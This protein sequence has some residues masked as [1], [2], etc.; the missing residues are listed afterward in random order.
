MNVIMIMNDSLRRDHIAAYGAPPPWERP[1]HAGEPFILTPNLDR[2]AAESALFERFYLSSYPTIPCRHDIFTGR[3]GFPS[4][5]WQ[6]LEPGDVI[7]SELVRQGGAT[8]ATIFDTPML[9]ADSY[10]FARGFAGWDFVRG[11]HSDRYI[12]DPIPTTL[13]AAPHKLKSVPATQLYLRNS[14]SRTS[15]NDWMCARTLTAAM[16][17]LERNRTR[18]DFVLCLDMWDPHEPFDAPDFDLARYADP[19]YEGESNIYPRYGRPDY[20]SAA[21]HN[22]VRALYAA[23]VT[24][25]D[26]WLGRLLEKMAALGLDK[27]TLLLFYTDHGHLFGEHNL[28]GKPTGPLGSLYEPTVRLPLLIRHPDGV[29]AGK[30][31]QGIAQ[32]PDLLPTVLEFLGIPTPDTVHGTS[33]WPLIRGETDD[34]RQFAV[35]GRYSRLLNTGP[36]AAPRRPDAE[37]FDGAAGVATEA[38]PLTLTTREWAYICPPR[39][40]TRE[41]YH[42]ETDPDQTD[43]V[44][45]RHPRVAADLHAKLLSFLEAHGAPADRIALYRDPERSGAR[46]ALMADETPLFT[47]EDG[48]GHVLAFPRRTAAEACLGPAIPP[49]SVGETTFGRLRR[50]SPRALVD[51]HEQYYWAEDLA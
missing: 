36:G 39:G 10:N 33:L 21:E 12:V 40:A 34:L 41:L 31:I 26:R 51:L 2:L 19:S 1:G 37:T 18:D 4:R 42:L 25:V 48:R 27:N 8:P 46:P 17:W 35:S 20:M 45:Q 47:L 29:G 43:N 13:P 16:S 6:P 3:Y 50:D 49:Q 7:L 22:H 24:V 15:E 32:H 23:L 44:L 11:Q 28:Q 38:E 5:G 30:R 9:V 14:A